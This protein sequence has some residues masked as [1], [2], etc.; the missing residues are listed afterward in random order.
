MFLSCP[1]P[2]CTKGQGCKG[3]AKHLAPLVQAIKL[4]HL[5]KVPSL[6]T[7]K[8]VRLIEDWCLV[9][10]VD[11]GWTITIPEEKVTPPL[12]PWLLALGFQNDEAGYFYL[13]ACPGESDLGSNQTHDGWFLIPEEYIGLG[14]LDA[15]MAD[16]IIGR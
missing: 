2:N 9:G 12:R 6:E 15:E 11:L 13:S 5:A 3:I 1:N 16:A 7:G 14:T 10:T 8:P 4:L